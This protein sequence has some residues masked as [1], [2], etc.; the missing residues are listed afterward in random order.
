MRTLLCAL[1]FTLAMGPAVARAECAA[2]YPLTTMAKDLGLMQSA[3]RNLDEEGFRAAAERLKAGMP[4]MANPAPAQVYATAYRLL[5]AEYYLEGDTEQA[6]AW[7]RTAIELDRDFVWDVRDFDVSHPIRQ[8]YEGQAWAAVTDPALIEGQELHLPASG[9]LIMDGRPLDKPAAT[10]RRPHVIQQIGAENTIANT[11][12]IEGNGFPAALLQPIS[13]EPEVAAATLV[14]DDKPS[15]DKDKPKKEKKPKRG[16]EPSGEGATAQASAG[17]TTATPFDDIHVVDR[18]RPPMKTP[19]LLL[20]GAGLLGA[21]G[22]YAASYL[23]H[24]KFEAATT[25]D[26][27][28]QLQ[29]TTNALVIASGGIAVLGVG[30][31]YWG[32]L[33]DGGV[34]LGYH[35]S[36]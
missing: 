27:A 25:T 26:D 10:P 34:G 21:G 18:V 17:N 30:L 12:I 35:R 28:N 23:M 1:A 24:Q 8:S 33:L 11:W 20:G 15:K 32:V 19:L 22:A 16:A 29:A 7:F 14:I 31:G 4:C 2:T 6:E 9:R 3:L 13:N 36:F 5:G